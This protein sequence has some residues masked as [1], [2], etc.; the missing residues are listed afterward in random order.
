MEI[1]GLGNKAT[2]TGTIS[3]SLGDPEGM[4]QE[5]RNQR[6]N[7]RAEVIFQNEVLK[8]RTRLKDECCA[9]VPPFAW[10][11]VLLPMP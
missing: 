11:P 1:K 9:L 10:A 8:V 2:T 5:S 7:N 3:I 4:Y 6:P